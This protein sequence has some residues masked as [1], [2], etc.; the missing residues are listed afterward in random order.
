LDSVTL[1]GGGE[2]AAG[3]VSELLTLAPNLVACDGAAARALAL[4]HVPKRVIG[5][6][7]SLDSETRAALDPDT[8]FE[9]AEQDSTDFDKALRHTR[10]PLVLGVGFSGARLDH[11]LAAMTVLTRYPERRVI[12]LGKET[13]VMLCPP[14]V[15]LDLAAGTQVSLYPMG[16]VGCDSEGLRWDTTGLR[17]APDG[18]V[19]TSNEATGPV[20][21]RP[22]APKMLLIL[23]REVLGVTVQALGQA[24]AQWSVR[25]G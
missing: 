12:L 23:P 25:A 1:L 7:D 6:L 5:D 15:R 3:T 14:E 21:L 11:E 2:L 22:D 19:G 18:R 20:T 10:A 17:F 13:F 24:D 9:M 8:V 16:E 4:G